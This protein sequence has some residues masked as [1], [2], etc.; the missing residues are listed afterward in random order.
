MHCFKMHGRKYRAMFFLVI[1]LKRKSTLRKKYF[2]DFLFP[3]LGGESL[4][5][6]RQ[7]L[8]ERICSSGANSFLEELT[9]KSDKPENGIVLS[10]RNAILP[11]YILKIQF[12]LLTG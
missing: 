1:L 9:G 5:E 7:L 8:T 2:C 3:S 6:G 11:E 10:F 4:S 12:T